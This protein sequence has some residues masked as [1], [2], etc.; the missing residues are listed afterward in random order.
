M[1]LALVAAGRLALTA[2]H[3]ADSVSLV[4]LD[5]QKLLCEVPCG[6]RP[7]AVAVSRDGRRVAVSNL[8]SDSLTLLE[9][10][11]T[12]LRSLGEVAIGH[13]PRGLCFT[14]T[15]ASLFVALGGADQ[16]VELDWTSRKIIRRFAAA[17]EPRRL[18]LTKSGKHLVA[19]SMRSSQV[20]CWNTETGELFWERAI[21]DSFNL[22]DVALTPDEE[23]VITT[24]V[25]TRHHPIVKH[26]IEQGWAL[27][28]RAARMPLQSNDSSY[29]QMAL[30]IRNRA[31][32]DPTAVSLTDKGDLL[33]IVAAGTQE[34]LLIQTEA[35]PWNPGEA[36][37]FLDSS[38]DQ[39]D[40]KFRRVP[41]GGRPLAVR[42][43][44]DGQ[45]AA[46]ANYLL[47]A[48]QIVDLRAGTVSA[49]IAL[50]GPEKPS[51]ARLG[52]AIFY[53]AKRS[54][55]QWFSCHTC[56]PDGHTSARAFDTF[57]DDSQNNPKMTPTL[58]GVTRTAP[59]TWHG[60]QANLGDAVEKSIT[61]TLYGKDPTKEE[62]EAVVAFLGTLEHPPNPHLVDG[63][64]SAAAERGKLLFEGKARCSRCHQG[65]D[66]TSKANYDVK[67]PHDGS[68]FDKWN[69]PTLRGVYD[70]GPYL[71]DGSAETLDELLRTPHAP[72]KLG[73]KALTDEERRDLVEFLKS[74]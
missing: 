64:R 26:N 49:T 25:H 2:N 60:W 68:P 15:G 62:I 17:R 4:D 16:V 35:I 6:R 5:R 9:L 45:R 3:T 67:L 69:P 50:G 1:D 11:G 73:G 56:H 23:S 7:S 65:E 36:G 20:R 71:H 52:E 53:D 42:F 8:W 72:E 30:D 46:V 27:N 28:S 63:K 33:G 47:D 18:A 22:M 34:L 44:P 51:A 41:L 14:P 31:V 59:Y 57:N 38:L 55:H 54:H 39:E 21:H 61:E 58:R 40:G 70:R 19:A 32:G 13:Q 12:E 37:D 48:V 43:L 29:R 10:A 66:Y 74:L 24:Q